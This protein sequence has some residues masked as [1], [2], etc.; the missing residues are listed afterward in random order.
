MFNRHSYSWALKLHCIRA[1]SQSS[2]VYCTSNNPFESTTTTFRGQNP[3]FGSQIPTLTSGSRLASYPATTET[4]TYSGY[5]PSGILEFISTMSGY[6]NKSHEELRWED[7]QLITNL[8]I[9]ACF[10]VPPNHHNQHLEGPA[11][12]VHHHQW[13]SVASC[14]ALHFQSLDNITLVHQSS[15]ACHKNPMHLRTLQQT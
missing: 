5:T 7:Y 9:E 3:T 4:K 11:T 13:L 2:Y 15:A 12:S 1:F 8:L 6:K 14:N 10:E